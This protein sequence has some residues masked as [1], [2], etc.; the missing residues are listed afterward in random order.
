MKFKNYTRKN[1]VESKLDFDTDR[2]VGVMKDLP[3]NDGVLVEDKSNYIVTV[4]CDGEDIVKT[5]KMRDELRLNNPEY[6]FNLQRMKSSEITND[7][8]AQYNNEFIE[9]IEEGIKKRIREKNKKK[10]NTHS[11]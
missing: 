3:V 11:I 8:S 4:D 7:Y 9:K 5:K 10:N 1:F 2:F 6:S